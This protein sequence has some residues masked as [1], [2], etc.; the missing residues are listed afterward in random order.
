MG[1]KTQVVLT[2]Y[3]TICILFFTT[4]VS[5]ADMGDIKGHW[6]EEVINRW[7]GKDLIKGFP[8]G[9][10]KPANPITR[11]EYYSLL[12]RSFGF[13]KTKDYQF[14]DVSPRDWFAGEIGKAN[15]QGYLKGFATDV[16]NPNQLVTR[17]EVVAVLGKILKLKPEISAANNF[18]DADEF[19]VWAREY[20][21][22]TTKL[23]YI[24]GYPDNTFQ[25]K[26]NISRAEVVAILDRAIGE[27]YNSSG[28]YGSEGT[29]K[30]INGNVTVNKPDITLKNMVIDGHL[31][32]TE[33]IGE[34]TITL[35]GVTVTG[36]TTISGGEGSV[37]VKDS[38][39]SNV[40]VNSP[41][42]SI[43]NIITEGASKFGTV[44]IQSNTRLEEGSLNGSGLENVLLNGPEGVNLVLLGDF[45][46]VEI[47]S[48]LAE[49]SI[50]KGKI[51]E[52][53]INGKN[54]VVSAEG[55]VKIENLIIN[56]SAK[57]NG[58]CVIGNVKVTSSNVAVEATPT[59]NIDVLQGL[60][61][62]S[63]G[64]KQY[65]RPILVGG[66]GGGG[67]GSSGGDDGE[68]KPKVTVVSVGSIPDITKPF[69]TAKRELGLPDKVRVTLSNNTT[70]E[71][72]VASWDDGT[73]NF[74]GSKGT[75]IFKG[76]LTMP[77]GVTNLNNTKAKVTVVIESGGVIPPEVSVVSVGPIPD[78]TKPYG[79]AK[80]ELGLPDKVR[81]TLSNN[82]TKEVDVAS[83]DDGTPNFT[84]SGGTY[85]FKGIL[86]MPSG[87]TNPSNKKARVTVVIE[88]GGV[89]PPEVS[90]VSVSPIP[91]IT[92]PYGTAKGE[93]GLPDK[94]TVTLSNNTTEEVGVASW[95][96]G[97]PNFT[98]SEGTYI[99]KGILTMPSGVTNPSNIKAKVTVVIGEAV[100]TY[101]ISE[102]HEYASGLAIE[103]PEAVKSEVNFFNVYHKP[104]N[105]TV[106]PSVKPVPV[107]QY[108]ISLPR[109]FTNID[110]LEVW[111]YSDQ[112]GKNKVA[113]FGL[114]PEGKLILKADPN[115]LF[116]MKLIV[117]SELPE[118]E[119]IMPEE[120][121]IEIDLP[122]GQVEDVN[123]VG[124]TPFADI[125]ILTG[126]AIEDAALPNS[127]EIEL[128]NGTKQMME[129][130]WDKGTPVYDCGT[131]Q[132]YNF[133][134]I[135]CLPDGIN[136]SN[137]IMAGI[138][139]IV[140]EPEV[141][142]EPELPT[143]TP[144]EES[145]EEFNEELN[146][147]PEVDE[148]VS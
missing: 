41:Y 36:T 92:K 70:K 86:T 85:I 143:L 106:N 37:T 72:D 62:V 109:V 103:V 123:V 99:F 119:E 52:L 82:T 39:L 1:K 78:I 67:G 25:P 142:G 122:E 104:N 147:D 30:Q 26:N 132:V 90:V 48:P 68:T 8:G 33:G 11:V 84:G 111:A 139:I 42:A 148:E 74:T 45:N 80:G 64:G 118:I 32:L 145:D 71:V 129:V 50:L 43:I 121:E 125:A 100:A 27:L 56:R 13:S 12:N 35:D 14:S 61:E 146:E 134:G 110:N 113:E 115:N 107:G 144:K 6:A 98:G 46:K 77:S 17:Q 105:L 120:T 75:Y 28:V 69:G 54:T 140:E 16:L 7:V 117:P 5:L 108:L 133:I 135:L 59:G 79:T 44:E 128:S 53:I 18:T 60:T 114:F 136:N 47:E 73:P 131:A 31:Y 65:P 89:T 87:V 94:I 20:I 55:P 34:G 58:K 112:E 38:I 51:K 2:V 4:G 126:T 116:A 10:F 81:V 76:I 97:T 23:G 49:V 3:L 102:I 19:A 137:N 141:V 138:R 40:V 88:S 96:D 22:A 21:N 93:L 9:N 91:D 29:M 15:A 83:W 101:T 24:K 124:I 95:D 127:V 130:K 66:G 63:I 57:V